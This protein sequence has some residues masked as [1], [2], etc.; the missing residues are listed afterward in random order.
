[1]RVHVWCY[2][3]DLQAVGL[4][5]ALDELRELGVQGLSVATSYHAGRFLQPRFH[6]SCIYYPEDGTVHVPVDE[7]TG[8]IVPRSSTFA[9]QHPD[10]LPTLI[11]QAAARGMTVASWTVMLHN[12]RLGTAHP[13]A[14]VKNAFG[15]P[16]VYNL[17]PSH[18]AVRQYARELLRSLARYEGLSVIELESL[19]YMGF[20]HE[21]HHEKDGVGLSPEEAFLV[22]LC[23]CPYCTANA[24]AVGVDV[25]AA[26]D[27]TRKRLTDAFSRERPAPARP[28]ETLWATEVLQPYLA[29]RVD[30]VHALLRELRD[31]LPTGIELRVLDLF[32]P[33]LARFYGLDYTRVLQDADSVVCCL[34]ERS[35]D[36][37]RRDAADL[38]ASTGGSEGV[39]AG[40]RLFYPEMLGR[41]DFLEKVLVTW[42]AGVRS[43]YFYNYG[44]VPANRLLWIRAFREAVGS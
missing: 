9:R 43:F 27:Y 37:L 25:A 29:W 13:E 21:F 14:T 39:S 1:M 12:T 40:F 17:C 41:E 42:E 28:L 23:F 18:P 5:R 7:G 44:L 20:V 4:E 15:D 26:R 6:D 35:V 31:A 24:E 3:W 34:Y 32:G 19:G 11:K 30:H 38:L 10:L 8:E 22:S 33:R 2:P 16:L 36:A